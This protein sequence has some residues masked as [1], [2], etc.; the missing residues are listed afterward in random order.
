[1]DSPKHQ[2]GYRTA[3]LRIVFGLLCFLLLPLVGV[4]R[5]LVYWACGAYL[6][7][8]FMQQLLTY[9]GVSSL[10]KVW[11]GGLSDLA[12]VTFLI[13]RLGSTETALISLYI[14]IPVVY[15]MV[16]YA[17]LAYALGIAGAVIYAAL[18]YAEYVGLLPVAPDQ[19]HWARTAERPLW[20]VTIWIV[21][22]CSIISTVTIAVVRIARALE[23]RER[24]LLDANDRLET[25]SRRDALTGLANRRHLMD[26]LALEIARV[27]R[28]HPCSVVM[29]DLDGFKSV[30]DDLG[31]LK[32][33]QVLRAVAG[34][35]TG[36]TRSADLPGRYG[37]DEFL[38]VLS[39]SDPEELD[40]IGDRLLHAIREAGVLDEEH[41][42]TGS[43][44][45]AK[46]EAD[47]TPD[48]A[49]RRA[50]E[51]AYEAKRAAGDQVVTS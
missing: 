8:A 22:M 15:A 43:I 44:G 47:D 11:I 2:L 21:I 24:E 6:V 31:H 51:N 23:R 35:I 12:F 7:A 32:G 16:G 5:E 50:D 37:G 9:R 26:R 40:V 18:L 38:I 27:Q 39:D 33:D 46:I 42:V 14:A 48:S 34:A 25:M 29:I 28:G 45:I 17:R 10:W 19:P 41:R 4:N 36:A 30:N 49:I 1:V 13:H 20:G 3:W